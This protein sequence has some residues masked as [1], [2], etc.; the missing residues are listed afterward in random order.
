MGRLLTR[1]HP[2]AAAAV[3]AMIAGRAPHA[4]LLAGAAGSGKTTLALD[5]AA[6]LLCD[7]PDPSDRPCRA[8]RGCRLVAHGT[9]ADV[10]RLA[11]SGPGLQVR[12]G[13]RSNPE[14]GTVRRLIADIALLP[15][16]GGNRVAIVE[17]ADRL[18]EDAQS[19]LLKILE[20]PPPG[21]T[22]VLCADRDDLLLPTVLSRCVRVRLGPV[23]IREIEAI[24]EDAA[25]ADAPRAN[26]LARLAWGRPG[27]ALALA[28]AP[29]AVTARDEIARTLIDLAGERAARRLSVGR[30]LL[31]RA[32]ELVSSLDRASAAADAGPGAETGSGTGSPKRSRPRG[33]APARAGDVRP[34]RAGG[35]TGDPAAAGDDSGDAGEG[36]PAD[37]PAVRAPATE[38]RRAAAALID[39]W[40]D[41]A[42]DLLLVEL[43]EDRRLRD[44]ALLDDLRAAG[45]IPPADLRAFIGRL[46]RSAELLEANVSPEL[47]VDALLLAWPRTARAA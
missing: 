45:A 6:G 9:H 2:A 19:A 39:I 35:D 11:P 40:R 29:E 27:A 5:L 16:E 15:V 30:E 38:R 31:A 25:V 33:A 18:N 4:V 37:A 22:I 17:R 26:R 14:P 13:E 12:I 7:A 10:H 20:E 47:A 43:G 42:R 1:G 44:P 32:G 24:L 8:C 3:Q 41:V 34:A 36:D 21:V 28:R 23:P 46:A